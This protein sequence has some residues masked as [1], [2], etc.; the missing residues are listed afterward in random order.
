ML[1]IQPEPEPKQLTQ[2][3]QLEFQLEFEIK[4]INL[5]FKSIMILIVVHTMR[6]VINLSGYIVFNHSKY[7]M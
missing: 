7:N 4:I 1:H 3:D 6:A 5:S 2:D